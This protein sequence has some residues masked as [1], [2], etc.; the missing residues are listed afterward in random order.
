M[1]LGGGRRRRSAGQRGGEDGGGGGIAG[2]FEAEI[3]VALGAHILRGR[4]AEKSAVIGAEAV[5]FRRLKSVL[6][7]HDFPY[8]PTHRK[9][10]EII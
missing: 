8:F 1:R 9:R 3:S 10:F 6:F 7:R 4:A 5:A 2:V